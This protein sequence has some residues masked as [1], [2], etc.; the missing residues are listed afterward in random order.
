M[1]SCLSKVRVV[2]C[3]GA[4]GVRK[5]VRVGKVQGGGRQESQW[6]PPGN[7]PIGLRTPS[8][9]TRLQLQGPGYGHGE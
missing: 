5:R 8:T 7:T 4:G 3:V 6:G 9:T 1:V 2:L